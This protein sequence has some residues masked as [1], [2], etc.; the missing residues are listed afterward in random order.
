MNVWAYSW[1]IRT[2]TDMLSQRLCM[3]T[4]LSCGY[5]CVKVGK[6]LHRRLHV[7]CVSNED[8]VEITH[9]RKL[10]WACAFRMWRN[11][12]NLMNWLKYLLVTKLNFTNR[13]HSKFVNRTIRNDDILLFQTGF[14]RLKY[15]TKDQSPGFWI[16]IDWTIGY[17]SLLTSIWV[18]N[19]KLGKKKTVSEH[20]TSLLMRKLTLQVSE[21]CM[22]S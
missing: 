13:I 11:C 6:S 7:V 3:H 5:K 1:D 4:Q 14:S 2:N 18:C 10:F 8:S 16:P 22:V 19:F 15:D 17:N 21:I 20:T 9:L 12:W